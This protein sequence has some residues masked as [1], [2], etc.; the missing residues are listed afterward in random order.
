[1]MMNPDSLDCAKQACLKQ[2]FGVELT[3]DEQELLDRFLA[4]AVG[5]QYR[6]DSGEMKRL[7]GAVAEVEV[8]SAV[9]SAAMLTSFES[10]AR[11][12]LR[13]ARRRLPLLLLLTSGVGLL[14]GGLC[15]QSGKAALVFF[16]W[17]MLGFAPLCAVLF[18]AIWS[19]QG[20]WLRDPDLLIRMEEEREAGESRLAIIVA[21]VIGVLLLSILGVGLANA[22]GLQ[23]LGIA[24]VAAAV[25]I[26]IG[27]AYQRRKR[28]RNQEL[29]DWWYGRVSES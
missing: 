12:E 3:A 24:A 9:D 14:T 6:E 7:L 22:G 2:S 13:A 5:Q 25:V 1:M 15:L 26:S 23:A 27:V 21:A 8:S 10:M 4:S 11:D 18:V 20:A 19:K 16:G 28:V 17:T 29:W